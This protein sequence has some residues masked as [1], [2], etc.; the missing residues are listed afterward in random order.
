MCSILAEE[1][2]HR[3]FGDSVLYMEYT[4]PGYVL[5]KKV[6]D[7][8]QQFTAREDHPPEVIFLQ[9]HGVFVAGK[10]IDDIK[11]TYRSIEQKIKNELHQMVPDPSHIANT[12]EPV[13]NAISSETG[14]AAISAHSKLIQHYASDGNNF[15][16]IARPF[17]P[18]IIVYC[19]SNYLFVGDEND[20]VKQIHRFGKKYGHLPKI[21]IVNNKGMIALDDSLK[22]AETAMEVFEDMMKLSY[23]SENFGG[24]HCMSDE[25]IQFINTWEVENYRRKINQGS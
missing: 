4:D 7:R 6:N 12:L 15:Q 25:Q 19:K 17:T 2:V 10:T 3:L 23:L 16:K 13:C 18:D 22:T 9:N 8:I 11:N 24:P 5:F 1:T 14:K 20:L 21:I